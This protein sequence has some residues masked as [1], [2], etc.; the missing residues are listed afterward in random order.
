M[1]ECVLHRFVCMLY[2]YEHFVVGGQGFSDREMF[3][4]SRD[5]LVCFDKASFLSDQPD[6]HLNF[7]AAFLE[8]QVQ[9]T[10]TTVPYKGKLT[11]W[12]SRNFK[13]L[14]KH[15]EE[16]VQFLQHTQQF[17]MF[18]SFIDCK[19][20]SQWEASDE[21]LVLFDVRISQMRDKLGL[22]MVRTPTYETSPPFAHSEELINK[23]EETLD[24]I[25]PE[26][27]PLAG[28]IALKWVT[29]IKMV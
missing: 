29:V 3:E 20:L 4:A 12:G 15:P 28:A 17:Q 9:P 13:K 14:R 11:L 8:T 21:N 16:S 25:I 10:K 23:R 2:S 26:P 18:A 5:S 7:L 24:Y 22:S 1:R 6:S 27:H 19:I